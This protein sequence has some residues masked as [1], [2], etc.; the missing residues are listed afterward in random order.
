MKILTFGPKERYDTYRPDFADSLPVEEV[1]SHIDRS[2]LQ[3]AAGNPDAQVIFTDTITDVGE[4]IITLLPQLKLIQSEGV[5]FNRID[6]EAA[7]SRGIYVCNNKGFN[8]SS[9][10][11]HTIMLML[12]ALRHGVTGDRAVREGRQIQMKEAVMVSNSPELGEQT[13][14]L[15][16]FGDIAQALARR[17]APFGCRLLY[18]SLHRRSPEVE[19]QFGVTYLPLEELAAQCTILSLHCA[20]NQQTRRMVNAA[21]LAKMRPG[22]ILVNTARGDLMDDLA[23]REALISG[24]LGG[25]AFDTLF[26]E[27]TPADH[28]LVD[29]PPEVRDKVVYSPHLGGITG[30]SFRRGHARMWNNVRLLL[31]GNRPECVV[32]GL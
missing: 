26:P 17:L 8:S 22:A 15:V 29:L 9:V 27:P 2:P 32:N 31:E 28:P 11:E 25:A 5:A 18:Y 4:D 10:A 20:V 30:G 3:A 14:G 13:V 19:A 12:M 1:Y 23:V 16:G 7:R 21:L 24:Q 6:L